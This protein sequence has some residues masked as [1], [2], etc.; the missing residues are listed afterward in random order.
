[1]YFLMQ[2][3]RRLGKHSILSS[4]QTG[5]SFLAQQVPI[6]YWTNDLEHCAIQEVL[7]PNITPSMPTRLLILLSGQMLS[8]QF[9][10]S[11]TM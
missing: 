1:M 2:I 5:H 6:S 9:Q 3:K 11:E 10:F 7:G 4:C 8:L